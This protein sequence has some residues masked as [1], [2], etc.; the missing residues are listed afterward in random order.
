MSIKSVW[1]RSRRISALGG[2]G[3][4]AIAAFAVAPVSAQD[5]LMI[6]VEE[7]QFFPAAE[8]SPVEIAVLWGDP[9]NGPAGILLRLPPGFPGGMHYHSQ[10]Y[11]AVVVAG[12][13]RFGSDSLT[14]HPGN[15]SKIT[16]QTRC[17]SLS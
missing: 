13:H 9:V 12:C 3:C 11:H 4:L 15:E 2:A 5:F 1:Q 7:L 17:T 14:T 10:D 8:G 6:P 16:S